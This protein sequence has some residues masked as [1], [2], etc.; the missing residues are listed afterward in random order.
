M[1][2]VELLSSFPQVRWGERAQAEVKDVVQDS[3]RAN[4]SSVFV[5]IR[6]NLTDGHQFIPTLSEADQVLALVVEDDSLISPR[7]RG[8]VVKV[9]NA[10]KALDQ[11][12]M[13]FYGNP[14]QSLFCIGVTGTNGK[15]TVTY[16][17]EKILNHFGWLTGVM[18]TIDHHVNGHRWESQLTTPDSLTL[19]SRL[20]EFVNLRARAAAFEVSSHA[21]SQARVES[22]PFRVGIFT[23]FTRDHLDYHGDMETY[24]AA[25]ERLFHELLPEGSFAVLNK[26]DAWIRKLRV[27]PGVHVWWFGKAENADFRFRILRHDLMGSLFH[28][29][30]P[31]G[32]LEVML[33]CVGEHNVYNAVAAIAA[34]LAAGCP[35]ALA[36]EALSQFYGAPGRLQKVANSRGIHIFVDYA[37][38]DD[39]V[40]TVL[41]A[42]SQLKGPQARIITVFGCGGDRDKGK[43]PLMAQAACE[44]SDALIIT[45]DNPRT[46]DPLTII[47]DIRRGIPQQWSGNLQVEADRKKALALALQ[48]AREGDVILIAGKGHENYQILG[49]Q[50]IDFSD[51]KVIAEL[52]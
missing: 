29:N 42:L 44:F 9:P 36:A 20:R 28:L 35:L 32:S 18:G 46:E 11:L 2:L 21:L 12:A 10:R 49:T 41:R 40:R 45:S 50:K 33:P 37:H 5:A 34:T 4:A 13:R 1:N 43:R 17:V 31:K 52:L 16:M 7:F 48:T 19:H 38:T 30:T 47:A 26:D 24:F 51:A 6:G 23:N 8:A 22:L 25:K 3:R 15:T 27:R 14:A 39:A